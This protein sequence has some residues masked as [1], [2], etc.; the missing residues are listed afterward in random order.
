MLGLTNVAEMELH[1]PDGQ[2][3][4]AWYAMPEP[5]QPTLFYLH[6]NAGALLHRVG[7]VQL[8]R[9]Q[10]YGVF[11]L[12]YRG[13]SGSTG[14]PSETK[15]VEDALMA[16]DKLSSFT[17]ADSKIV[18]YGES[19]G[20]G[21]AIQ[22]AAKRQPA[23]VVLESPFSSAVDVGAHLYPYLPV[24]WLLKD[25]FESITYI[26]E[27]KAPLLVLHGERDRIV[28]PSLA[29]KLFAAAPG[30]KKA[31]FIDEATHYTLYEHGAFDKVRSFLDGFKSERTLPRGTIPASCREGCTRQ[32]R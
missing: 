2:T 23:G 18:I 7:R 32:G 1:T 14:T 9:S 21:V 20:T 25:R 16:F 4:V 17:P 12:A 28:P 10:G 15:I 26:G 6:G 8:Y 3:L 13:F 29:R 31:Y 19:L 22:V 5:G 30:P 27:V 11:L 24:Y